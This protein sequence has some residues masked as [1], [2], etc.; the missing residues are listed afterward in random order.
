MLNREEYNAT[1][2][3]NV[4]EEEFA[5]IMGESVDMFSHEI[6]SITAVNSITKEKVEFVRVIRCKDCKYFN[7]G[8]CEELPK[9]VSEMDYCSFAKLKESEE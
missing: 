3:C 7:D 2:N 6:D 5:R 4:N 1:F 9:I 8:D